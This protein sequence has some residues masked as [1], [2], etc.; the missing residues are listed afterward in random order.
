MIDLYYLG[1][2]ISYILLLPACKKEIRVKRQLF[3]K[4]VMTLGCGWNPLDTSE[5]ALLGD[6]LFSRLVL[7]ILSLLKH[8]KTIDHKTIFFF[9]IGVLILISCSW[10]PPPA[11]AVA[12]RCY[13]KQVFLEILQNS[14]ENICTRVSFLI[15]S[16]SW[17]CSFIKK[18]TLARDFLRTPF[19]TEHIRWLFLLP[20]SSCCCCWCLNF[21]LLLRKLLLLSSGWVN[22]LWKRKFL[23]TSPENLG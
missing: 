5:L 15:K 14:Q 16:H 21:M 8:Q 3:D 11:E 4:R 19:L 17:E 9:F 7:I 12:R 22:C 1:T 18:E 6:L 20:F 23:I 13:V 2:A 10:I